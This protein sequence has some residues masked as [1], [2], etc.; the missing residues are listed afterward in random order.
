MT[1]QSLQLQVTQHVAQLLGADDCRLDTYGDDDLPAT[2]IIPDDEDTEPEDDSDDL[3]TFKF[4]VRWIDKL[5][6]QTVDGQP[7]YDARSACDARFLAADKLIAADLT[8]GGLVRRCRRVK[9]T[10]QMEQAGDRQVAHVATYECEF[11]TRRND[12]S[13]GGY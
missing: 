7:T 4:H 1:P 5:P 12:P 9:R 13:V 11:T 2:N 8:L 3:N 10:W 6:V